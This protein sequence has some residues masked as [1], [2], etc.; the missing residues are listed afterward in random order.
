MIVKVDHHFK[1]VLCSQVKHRLN[2][3]PRNYPVKEKNI[4]PFAEF[5]GQYF[6]YHQL[7][8]R[9]QGAGE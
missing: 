6:R 1:P 3:M 7:R 4:N 2:A 5:I 9:H 8:T